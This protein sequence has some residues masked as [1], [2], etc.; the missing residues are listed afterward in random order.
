MS[1]RINDDFFLASTLIKDTDYEMFRILG[2]D[3]YESN[4][5][6]YLS[7][8]LDKP[9]PS[10]YINNNNARYFINNSDGSFHSSPIEQGRFFE[11]I[12]DDTIYLD[13]SISAVSY[14]HLTLPTI[15]LV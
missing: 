6:T 11:R 13:Y 2:V 9:L 12:E 15:L 1:L 8:T 5:N 10:K 4:D 7:L 14:T 3:T